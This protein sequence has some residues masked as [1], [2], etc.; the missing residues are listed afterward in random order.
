ML[1]GSA[2]QLVRVRAVSLL[3]CC[4]AALT[5]LGACANSPS[6]PP[7]AGKP[8]DALPRALSAG[9]QTA[10]AAGNNFSFALLRE[11][12]GRKTAGNVF[13]SPLS[14]SMALGMTLNG[15]AGETESAMRHTLGLD[16]QT[17]PN[18]NEAYRGLSSLLLTL[19]PAV[20][21]QSANSIWYRQGFSVEQSFLDASRTFFAADVRPTNFDD[22]A[23]SLRSINGWA[24][25]KTNG[26]IDKVLT[27]IDR[28][29]VMYL[30]NALYFKGSWRASFDAKRTHAAPFRNADGSTSSVSM[31]SHDNIPMRIGGARGVQIGEIAYGNG[32]YVMDVLLPAT[33]TDVNALVA[34]LDESQWG[35]LLGSMRETE[36]PVELPKFTLT[37]S[38]IWNDP[39]TAMGMGV[40]FAPNRADFSRLSSRGR[41]IYISLVKQ[42]AMVDVNEQGT[43]AAAVTV[44]GMHTTSMP[45]PFAV[46]RAFVF[47][48]RERFSGAILFIGKVARLPG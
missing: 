30:M 27:S 41:E 44:V 11:V 17:S 6:G 31:M 2:R 34:G 32:A 46:N 22:V 37:Y 23:A 36:M 48:I 1:I 9:E 47:A 35:E 26:K 25:E 33:G 28:N 38:D 24:F 42:D 20:R 8:L 39:L 3:V 13:I 4:V 18:I 10:V 21:V 40:A 15:A 7:D 45:V 5:A 19:D 43:E 16:G 12:N 14:A 29:D